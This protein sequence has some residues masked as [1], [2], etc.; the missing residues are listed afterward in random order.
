MPFNYATFDQYVKASNPNISRF[1]ESSLEPLQTRLWQLGAAV[2]PLTLGQLQP[3]WGI[4]PEDKQKKYAGALGYLKQFVPGL[5]DAVPSAPK[6]YYREFRVM[7]APLGGNPT[8]PMRYYHVHELQW[9]SSNGNMQALAKVGTRERV[10]ARTNPAGPPFDPVIN[11]GIPMTFTQ[12]ATSAAGAQNGSNFDDHSTGN[13]ALIVGRP[14]T[15]GSCISDQV[16]EYTTDGITWLPIPGAVYEIEKGVRMSKGQM[17]FYFRKQTVAPHNPS[18]H[19]EVEY[20][21]GPPLPVP[22]NKIS[23]I[24]ASFCTLE[25]IKDNVLNVISLK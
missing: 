14:L 4:V 15:A 11:A 19:F 17:V 22:G 8:Y 5:A 1:K 16:Y 23:V 13:P 10:T 2:G 25:N 20:A 21:I 24:P 18:F 9:K 3:L 6:M 7:R 12:G